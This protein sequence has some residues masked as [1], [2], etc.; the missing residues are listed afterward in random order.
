[1]CELMCL[2]LNILWNSPVRHSGLFFFFFFLWELLRSKLTLFNKCT[3]TNVFFFCRQIDKLGVSLYLPLSSVW[4]QLL[5]LS[6]ISLNQCVV[7]NFLHYF[8]FLLVFM[9]QLLFPYAYGWFFLLF[10]HRHISG[11]SV[12]NLR[13]LTFPA[14]VIIL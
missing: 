13:P 1:M 4:W 5:M 10:Y 14:W 9:S 6:I 7:L 3:V 8:F 12:M 2:L 11:S